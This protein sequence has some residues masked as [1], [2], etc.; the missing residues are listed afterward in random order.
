MKWSIPILPACLALFLLQLAVPAWMIG[1]REAT[2]QLGKAFKFETAPVDPA[3]AFRG[4]YVALDVRERTAEAVCPGPSSKPGET[5]YVTLQI[6]P[7]GYAKLGSISREKPAGGDYI[8]AKSGYDQRAVTLPLD[9]FYM[10]ES[11]APKA[12]QAYRQNS[13]ASNR[14]ACILVRVRG[15]DAV[16][17]D[18]LLDGKPVR[19][20]LRESG[21]NK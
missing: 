7:D 20:Y 14:N 11:L 17:E 21:N 9:R 3:D 1:N 4:R 5:I 6:K 18:L 13:R 8:R 2:L 15:G 19:E 10:N 12:E 16:I